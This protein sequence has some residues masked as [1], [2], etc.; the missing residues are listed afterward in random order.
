MG[1]TK[2]MNQASAQLVPGLVK[3]STKAQ[4]AINA[5]EEVKYESRNQLDS[6][7]GGVT[8]VVHG[9]PARRPI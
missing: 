7:G 9:I 5:K 3:A 6:G 1:Q 4:R 8:G 2:I